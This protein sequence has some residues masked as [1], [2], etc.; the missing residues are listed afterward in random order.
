VF[1][2]EGNDTITHNI[3]EFIPQPEDHGR[4]L[5]CYGE[6][7]KIPGSGIEDHWLMNIVCKYM[8]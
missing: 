4:Q 5:K 3:L 8:S 2:E 7:S 6:N 1:Q